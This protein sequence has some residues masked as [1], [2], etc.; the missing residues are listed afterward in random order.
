MLAELIR[1]TIPH[2][3]RAAV[4]LVI[5]MA[6]LGRGTD[7]LASMLGVGSAASAGSNILS[8]L[9]LAVGFAAGVAFYYF[10]ARDGDDNVKAYN[11]LDVL[12][13]AQESMAQAA[14]EEKLKHAATPVFSSQGGEVKPPTSQPQPVSSGEPPAEPQPPRV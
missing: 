14:H 5:C 7:G 10:Q 9:C 12:N 3:I 1:K 11:E 6:A 8:M 13:H 4:A 2:S